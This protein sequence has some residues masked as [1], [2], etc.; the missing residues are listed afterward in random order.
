MHIVLKRRVFPHAT[1]FIYL[2]MLKFNVAKIFF[3]LVLANMANKKNLYT[4]SK[5]RACPENMKQLK[6]YLR[7]HPDSFLELGQHSSQMKTGSLW[8]N[9]GLRV[10]NHDKVTLS[11]RKNQPVLT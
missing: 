5:D 2:E 7:A 1:L 9:K 6:K 3:L 8:S 4:F 11:L 10:G